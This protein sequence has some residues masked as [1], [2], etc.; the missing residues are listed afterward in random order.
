MQALEIS[1]Q[2]QDLAHEA[3]LT[4]IGEALW[5][6]DQR[7]DAL[8]VLSIRRL[9]PLAGSM[10]SISR[11]ECSACRPDRIGDRN[12]RQAV[13]HYHQALDLS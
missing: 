13:D 12:I 6:Y 7:D 10:I 2:L 5:K 9:M 4:S 1:R 8:R 11:P 3:W